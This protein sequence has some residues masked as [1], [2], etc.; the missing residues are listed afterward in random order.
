MAGDGPRALRLSSSWPE[1]SDLSG[2]PGPYLRYREMR[3]I[4]KAIATLV[5]QLWE[6]L[7]DS[8]LYV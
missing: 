6:M 2:V 1:I 8:W 3:H 4:I 7:I 5:D